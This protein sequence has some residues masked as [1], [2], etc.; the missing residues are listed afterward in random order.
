MKS[1]DKWLFLEATDIYRYMSATQPQN[2]YKRRLYF[3]IKQNNTFFK[4]KHH[5]DTLPFLLYILYCIK[6]LYP[7]NCKNKKEL[8][9]ISS[10]VCRTH[11]TPWF[12]L[13]KFCY[14]DDL[15]HARHVAI[16]DFR[17]D[18]PHHGAF[19]KS[20][21]KY[22]VPRLGSA[23]LPENEKLLLEVLF[24]YQ[25]RGEPVIFKAAFLTLY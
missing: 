11:L 2:R 12:I 5:I 1:G 18:S 6:Y 20:L 17:S 4:Q 10:N 19:G 8:L 3:N 24:V 22:R 13:I 7:C 25:T 16:D 15:N 21:W 14:H 9:S 23:S